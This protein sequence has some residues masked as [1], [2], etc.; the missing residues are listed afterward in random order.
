MARPRPEPP[1]GRPGAERPEPAA[2]PHSFAGEIVADIL[3]PHAS[4]R[5]VARLFKALAILVALLLVAEVALALVQQGNDAI[6]VLLVEAT[7]LVVFAGVLWGLGDMALMFIESN[8]DIRAT[9]VLVWQLN[10]MLKL[11]LES[12]GVRVD[13]VR[14][15]ELGSRPTLGEED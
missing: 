2:T 4:L 14:P 10:G 3:E 11:G 7:R 12:Q 13:P 6:P 15:S 1:R 5:Y 8:H 9:R